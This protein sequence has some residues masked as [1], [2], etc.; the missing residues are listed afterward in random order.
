SVVGAAKFEQVEVGDRLDDFYLLTRLGS[1]AFA[2]VFLA[3]QQSMQRLVAL[4]VSASRGAEPQTLAQLDHP[5]IVRVF[6]QRQLPEAG[7]SLMYMQYVAGGTLQ[8]VIARL[9]L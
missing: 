2:T 4:K 1:G 6:D 8:Q 3:R 5:S 7:L 9:Q